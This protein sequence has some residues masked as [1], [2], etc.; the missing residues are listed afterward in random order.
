[1]ADQIQQPERSP[2]VPKPYGTVCPW[3]ITHDTGAFMD[4]A[5]AAFGAKEIARLVGE[6]GSIGHAELFIGESVVLAFDARPQWPPTPAFL[7]IYVDDADATYQ[8]AVGAG[9]ELVTPL[10][11]MP[12]GDRAG[13]VRDPLGNLWWIMAR[14]EEVDEAELTRRWG[15]PKYLEVMART[16]AFDPFGTDGVADQGL[17]S[18]NQPTSGASSAATTRRS[19]TASIPI[20]PDTRGP[21]PR[22]SRSR[23]PRSTRSRPSR[24]RDGYGQPMTSISE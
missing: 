15:E 9:A 11:D 10:G 20:R 22:E 23:L 14:M 5:T 4:F 2:R 3:V 7:R 16:T 6:D 24:R 12:W 18:S 17:V 13:R 19:P 21:G 1:M 8:R